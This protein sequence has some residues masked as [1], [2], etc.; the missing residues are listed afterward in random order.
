MMVTFLLP[1]M[2][3]QP[4]LGWGWSSKDWRPLDGW[5]VVVHCLEGG[6]DT[7]ADRGKITLL[8]NRDD[9]IDLLCPRNF[10][11]R[12][13]SC[14]LC[15]LMCVFSVRGPWSEGNESGPDLCS[16]ARHGPTN[17]LFPAD[18]QLSGYPVSSRIDRIFVLCTVSLVQ[19]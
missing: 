8:E 13:S 4:A 2:Y 10:C 17:I 11:L 14:V 19:P 9:D 7:T 15:V 16:Q 12:A 18:E 5:P 6:I 1:C 3:L